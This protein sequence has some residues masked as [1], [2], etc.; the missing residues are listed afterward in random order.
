MTALTRAAA[1]VAASLALTA[2]AL[3]LAGGVAAAEPAAPIWLLPGADVGPLL[4]PVAG[5]PADVL[6]PIYSVLTVLA[7]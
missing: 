3:G 1:R 7:G 4:G 6:A 5:V 2:G